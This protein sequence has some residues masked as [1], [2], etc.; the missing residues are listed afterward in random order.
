MQDDRRENLADTDDSD[1]DNADNKEDGY[2]EQGDDKDEDN[3]NDE[4]GDDYDDDDVHPF[5]SLHLTELPLLRFLSLPSPVKPVKIMND[6][7]DDDDILR[8]DGS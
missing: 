2:D 1:H 8:K 5:V 4:V 7:H 6:D 3:A